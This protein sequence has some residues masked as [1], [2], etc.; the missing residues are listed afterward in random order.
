MVST[1]MNPFRH[2]PTVKG[3][4]PPGLHTIARNSMQ[5]YMIGREGA[6]AGGGGE[7]G[8]LV[9]LAN[10]TRRV[11]WNLRQEIR[12]T[13]NSHSERTTHPPSSKGEAMWTLKLI[14][15]NDGP[16]NGSVV[17]DFTHESPTNTD[18]S[19][20]ARAR[21]PLVKL[22]LRKTMLSKTY[23]IKFQIIPT[24]CHIAV[25]AS[26]LFIYLLWL[27]WKLLCRAEE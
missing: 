10:W 15:N 4:V 5:Q 23:G 21:S 20:S 24:F 18:T 12:K 6:G 8:R 13:I 3:Y 14:I 26:S 17:V 22:F 19:Y 2:E 11:R 25:S 16:C 27:K 1:S 9:S 7:R